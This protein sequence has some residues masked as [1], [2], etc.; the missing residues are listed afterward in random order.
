M[1][2]SLE[3]TPYI[4]P[5]PEN[6]DK[7]RRFYRWVFGSNTAL[8]I[9]RAASLERKIYQRDLIKN[10]KYSNKTII[11]TLK[12][13]VSLKVLQGGMEKVLLKGR[14]VWVKWYSP[15]SMGR[16]I[17][18]LF[19]PPKQVKSE[20]V[21]ETLKQLFEFYIRHAIQLC[22]TYNLNPKI[23]RAVFEDSIVKCELQTHRGMRANK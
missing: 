20:L 23:L 1:V 2:Q 13:L 14:L 4:L 7:Q 9:L 16:W 8:D 17:V 3:F 11:E 21:E 5:L 10:L 6:R 12:K 15:T 19:L 22:D 18:L